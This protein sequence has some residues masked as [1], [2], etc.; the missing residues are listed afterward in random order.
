MKEDISR[1]WG[2][3]ASPLLRRETAGDYKR[4]RQALDRIFVHYFMYI[5]LSNGARRR[6]KLYEV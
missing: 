2:Q 5:V 4:I 6:E 1:W 3:A